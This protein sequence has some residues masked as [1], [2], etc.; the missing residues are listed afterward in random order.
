[1]STDQAVAIIEQNIA[2]LTE[3]IRLDPQN[4]AAYADRAIVEENG[5]FAESSG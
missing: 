5:A 1:M 4:A 3:A 2:D